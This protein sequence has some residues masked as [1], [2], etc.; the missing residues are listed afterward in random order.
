LGVCVP[1][2]ILFI[3]ATSVYQK[4]CCENSY[5][6]LVGYS[7]GYKLSL[8]LGPDSQNTVSLPG[9]AGS[10]CGS[11]RVS[12]STAATYYSNTHPKT[13]RTWP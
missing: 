11:R 7:V 8:H 1:N 12:T 3:L 13:C 6:L 2:R 5:L 4:H 9:K 10:R